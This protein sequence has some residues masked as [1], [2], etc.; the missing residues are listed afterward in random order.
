[1]VLVKDVELV[2]QKC[3]RAKARV[4]IKRKESDEKIKQCTLVEFEP[5][6]SRLQFDTYLVSKVVKVHDFMPDLKVVR[7]MPVVI[8]HTTLNFYRQRIIHWNIS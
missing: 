4:N 6:M 2:L 8:D 7:L 1:M 3:K 5:S